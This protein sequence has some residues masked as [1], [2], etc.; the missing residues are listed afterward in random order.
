MMATYLP[1][2]TLSRKTTYENVMESVY[3]LRIYQ[4]DLLALRDYLRQRIQS[5]P[6][7]AD[8]LHRLNTE[9]AAASEKAT[10]DAAYLDTVDAFNMAKKYDEDDVIPSYFFRAPSIC[11]SVLNR[12][13]PL[14]K[15]YDK[16]EYLFVDFEKSEGC[17][18]YSPRKLF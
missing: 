7:W 17:I 4:Y 1:L 6:G 3:L 9:I 5:S 8:I 15:L 2:P 11:C 16:Y 13:H 18:Y 12:T 14:V 10:Q